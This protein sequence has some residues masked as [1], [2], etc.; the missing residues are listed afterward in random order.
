MSVKQRGLSWQASITYKGKRHR[1]DF[2][3]EREAPIWEAQMKAD[4][5]SGSLEAPAGFT[6]PD[7]KVFKLRPRVIRGR[8]LP[9]RAAPGGRAYGVHALRSGTSSLRK[10]L[11]LAWISAPCKSCWVTS[12]SI[13]SSKFPTLRLSGNGLQ[14]SAFQVYQRP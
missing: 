10:C 7:D 4:L 12:G 1:K 11:A 9:M 13:R 5:L 6:N 3:N 2:P 14:S 8:W